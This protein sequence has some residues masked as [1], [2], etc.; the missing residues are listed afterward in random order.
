MEGGKEP[1]WSGQPARYDDDDDDDD[2]DV[3]SRETAYQVRSG[4][5]RSHP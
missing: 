4:Q 1:I 5:V 3:L 2:D